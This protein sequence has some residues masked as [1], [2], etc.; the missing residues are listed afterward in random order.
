METTEVIKKHEKG[1]I[2]IRRMLQLLVVL[3]LSLII[4]LQYG[5]IT[6]FFKWIWTNI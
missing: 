1:F 5:N 3:T 6:L 2:K 4:L